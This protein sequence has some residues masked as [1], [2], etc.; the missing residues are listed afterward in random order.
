MAR[1]DEFL[2]QST[3]EDADFPQ[4]VERLVALFAP[5]L[6]TEAVPPKKRPGPRLG[7]S[8]LTGASLS[9]TGLS[10]THVVA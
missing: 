4:T 10:A 7:A 2:R 8:Y 9:Q 1:I 6:R 3:D 5:E